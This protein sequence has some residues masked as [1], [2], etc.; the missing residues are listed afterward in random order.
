VVA[1]VYI[2]AHLPDAGESEA[3]DEK[4]FPSPVSTAGV[5]RKTPDG[6]T[7]LDPN[8]FPAYFAADLPLLQALFNA[9]TQIQ[10]AC[11]GLR[12][13]NHLAGI[14]DEAELDDGAGD[15]QIITPTL[16]VGI[17]SKPSQPVVSVEPPCS[18]SS[19]SVLSFPPWVAS[20]KTLPLSPSRSPAK[21]RETVPE[22]PRDQGEELV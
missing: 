15:D 20:R 6:Y 21:A 9:A 5:F 18:A 17:L 16:S 19:W 2:A 4:R 11:I 13:C 1:L 3:S 10:T 14:E 12:W 22:R 8:A 7:Y